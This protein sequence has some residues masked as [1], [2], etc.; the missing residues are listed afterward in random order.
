[1]KKRVVAAVVCWV[2]TISWM[3]FIFGMS[4]QNGETSAEISGSV[5]EA[6]VSV[7]TPEYDA[8]PEEEQKALVADW[9]GVV[10][11]GAHFCEY[12]VLGALLLCSL[13]LSLTRRKLAVSLA[14]PM[15]AI[16]AA[17][18]EWHQAFVGGRG[19]S[20]ADVGIDTLG[21]LLGILV[22]LFVLLLRRRRRK[23]KE[24]S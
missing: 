21:A 13:S 22:V 2:L 20:V 15:A 24:I 4:S 23:R 14:L 8:L 3:A 5:T 7:V 18:D 19:P 17:S 6:I 11:K 1:M 16:Y 12:A 9:H 10:R